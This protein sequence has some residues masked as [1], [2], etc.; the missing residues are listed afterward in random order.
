MRHYNCLCYTKFM[1][2]LIYI[3]VAVGSTIGG[4]L[5]S[6]LDGGTIFGVWGLLLGTIGAFVGIW[7][8]Y[9]LGQN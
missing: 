3:G 1:K 7:A 2:A 8:G 4:F 5:G 9:K 6:L